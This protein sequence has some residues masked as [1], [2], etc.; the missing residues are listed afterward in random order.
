MEAVPGLARGGKVTLSL[1][2][3]AGGLSGQAVDVNDKRAGIAFSLSPSKQQ[4]LKNSLRA[5][6]KGGVTARRSKCI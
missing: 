6:S 2:G 4:G 5:T 1:S 3:L